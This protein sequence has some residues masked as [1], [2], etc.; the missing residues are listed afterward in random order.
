MGDK[1]SDQGLWSCGHFLRLG[2]WLCWA[3]AKVCGYGEPGGAAGQTVRRGSMQCAPGEPGEEVK[4]EG[5]KEHV[6]QDPGDTSGGASRD[7]EPITGNVM[8]DL[9]LFFVDSQIVAFF[10][11]MSR[12][13]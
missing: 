7:Q 2:S 1:L 4:G 3:L 8:P 9:F 5:V 12:S 11:L 6:R 10:L 13:F